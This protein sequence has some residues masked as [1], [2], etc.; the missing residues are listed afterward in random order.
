[1][2]ATKLSNG[3]W[4]IRVADL[5]DFIKAR[6]NLGQKKVMVIDESG[7]AMQEMVTALEKLG[8]QVIAAHN[9]ADALLKAADLYPSLFIANV[10]LTQMDIWKLLKRIRN[11]RNI[12]NA[13][14]IIIADHDLKDTESEAAL[15]LGAQG[16]LRRPFK[17][18]TLIEE[19]KRIMSRIL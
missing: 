11:T 18:A 8:H 13:P 7:P 10:S 6:Q 15:E 3:Y 12:R 16:F 1:L 19:M 17:P 9:A 5:E 4:K 14:I 2:P